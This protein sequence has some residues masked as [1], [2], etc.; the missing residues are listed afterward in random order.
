M[1]DKEEPI[2]KMQNGD[3]VPIQL[4]RPTPGAATDA[5]SLDPNLVSIAPLKRGRS[6]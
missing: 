1:A 5:S 2:N 3:T 6:R 4:S